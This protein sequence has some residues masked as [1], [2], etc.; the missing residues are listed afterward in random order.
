VVWPMLDNKFLKQDRIG[1]KLLLPIE[2]RHLLRKESAQFFQEARL[3]KQNL[4]DRLEWS[5]TTL[6]DLCNARLRTCRA[7]AETSELTLRA[8]FTEDVSRE[9]IVDALDQ[10]H[11]P[12]DAFKFL[13]QVIQEHCQITGDDQA[14]Y[15]IPRLTLDTVRRTQSQRVQDLHRGLGP[16]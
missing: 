10:M 4:I 16:A 3:D 11:Q 1:L 13:Y 14:D 2:L 15:R 8:L 7:T 5:G 9:M 6:Y 12:R